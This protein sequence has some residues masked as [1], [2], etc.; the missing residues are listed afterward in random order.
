MFAVPRP[1]K[2]LGIAPKKRGRP[3]AVEEVVFDKEA[4]HEFLTGFHKRK[5]QRQK[6]AQE[7]AALREKQDKIRFRKQLKEDRQKQ[8]EDHVRTVKEMLM[9]HH[10]AG[11]LDSDDE[12]DQEWNGIAESDQANDEDDANSTTPKLAPGD[13]VVDIEEEYIDEDKFTTVKVESVMVTRDGLHKPGAEEAE[14]AE[15]RARA[16]AAA[17]EAKKNE[18]PKK[19]WPK[20][21]KKAKFRYENKVDRSEVR[22]RQAARNKAKRRKHEK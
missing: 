9:E 10:M 15:K 7:A 18:K 14:A 22:A 4:R 12:A 20:K 1:K 6:L 16:I 8:V 13:E 5:L 2:G 3:S 17:E 21:D 11:N 19:Q